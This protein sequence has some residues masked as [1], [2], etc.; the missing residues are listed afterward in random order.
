MTR[1]GPILTSQDLRHDARHG[2][3]IYTA[4]EAKERFECLLAHGFE[5]EAAVKVFDAIDLP[6]PGV[7]AQRLADLRKLGFADPVKMITSSPAILG[8]AIANI[9]GKLVYFASVGLDVHSLVQRFPPILGYN[10]DR[11][12]LCVRLSLP[13]IDSL[14]ISLSFLVTKDPATSTAAALLCKP[15]TLAQLRAAMRVR[16][17]RAGENQDVIA[18]HPRDKATLAYRRYRPVAPK[19]PKVRHG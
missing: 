5:D 6:A 10:I 18:K 16:A 17:G 1:V 8:Y 3:P 2:N 15:T 19:Q 14:D 13:L 12:R 11:I 9:E 4:A 7:I